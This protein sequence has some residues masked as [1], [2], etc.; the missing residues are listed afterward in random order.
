MVAPQVCRVYIGSFRDGRYNPVGK[1]NAD[2]FDKERSDLMRDLRSLPAAAVLRKINDM[3]KRTRLLK[4]HVCIM[5][6]LREKMPS[7]FGAQAGLDEGLLSSRLP[8]RVY[9]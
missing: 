2:L 7:M 6:K 5:N 1:E 3:V 8:I 4:V 9:T